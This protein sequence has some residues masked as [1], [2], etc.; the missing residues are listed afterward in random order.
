MK[1][2]SSNICVV[3][4]CLHN[5]L[6]YWAQCDSCSAPMQPMGEFEFET[7]V[8]DHDVFGACP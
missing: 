4:S 2:I 8:L 6:L 7:T 5:K 1:Y 3:Q